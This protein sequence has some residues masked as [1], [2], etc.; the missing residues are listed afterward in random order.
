MTGVSCVS[1]GAGARREINGTMRRAP[2]PAAI[3][4]QIRSI[5]ILFATECHIST[6]GSRLH[7]RPERKYF[8]YSSEMDPLTDDASTCGKLVPREFLLKL[9]IFIFKLLLRLSLYVKECPFK[10]QP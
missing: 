3:H 6:R 7:F 9:L 1:P 2:T 10:N 8:L 4:P 5:S